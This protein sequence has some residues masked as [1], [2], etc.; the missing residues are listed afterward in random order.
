MEEADNEKP[1]GKFYTLTILGFTLGFRFLAPTGAKEMLIFIR[2][3]VRVKLVY[4][5]RS[6]IIFLGLKALR[7]HSEQS[8]SS[9]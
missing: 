5:E 4:V 1:S 6:N 3:F 7:E 8:E 9:Q 2:S